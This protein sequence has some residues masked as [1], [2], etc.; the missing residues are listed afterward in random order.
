M[1]NQRKNSPVQRKV[2]ATKRAALL[3][4]KSHQEQPL[5]IAGSLDD[6]IQSVTRKSQNG[7]SE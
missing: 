1:H 4:G 5:N 6:L 3:R 2:R 7:P